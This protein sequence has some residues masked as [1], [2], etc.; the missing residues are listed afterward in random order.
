MEY[1]NGST[2]EQQTEEQN[3]TEFNEF[4]VS[5]VVFGVFGWGHAESASF[6]NI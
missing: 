2:G 5:D 4:G 3:N 1:I 6:V